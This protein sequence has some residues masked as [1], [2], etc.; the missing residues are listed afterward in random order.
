MTADP[1]R[2]K[3][4][5][6]TAEGE[7]QLTRYRPGALMDWHVDRVAR[8]TIILA[9]SVTEWTV[10]GAEHGAIGSV[11]AKPADAEH[12]DLVGPEG[13]VTFSIVA[14]DVRW[15]NAGE[16]PYCWPQACEIRASLIRACRALTLAPATGKRRAA[17]ELRNLT[18]ALRTRL[19]ASALRRRGP[20]PPWIHRIDGRLRLEGEP[21]SVTELA[22]SIGVHP[23]YLARAYRA[24]RGHSI[25]D[26]RQTA[27]AERAAMLLGGAAGAI[28]AV[29]AQAGFSDQSHLCRCFKRHFGVTPSEFQRL[30]A[31]IHEALS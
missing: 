8:I 2:Q 10:A 30:S 6:T 7:A 25:R 11:V 17:N 31:G 4:S 27:R 29:A 26:G 15:R 13:L 21:V 18:C 3:H 28:S 14:R 24:A 5:W 22:A 19:L 16:L 12:R 9:G 23:I 1:I 20:H